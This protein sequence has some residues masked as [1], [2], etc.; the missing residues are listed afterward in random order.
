MSGEQLRLN[1]G[2]PVE[3][4]RPRACG[5]VEKHSARDA[6]R[7]AQ[8]AQAAECRAAATAAANRAG[9]SSARERHA[10]PCVE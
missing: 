5:R 9:A 8:E 10:P 3:P 2:R 7:T 4:Q 6:P 1:G